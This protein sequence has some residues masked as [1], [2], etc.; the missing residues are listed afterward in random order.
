MKKSQILISTYLDE[1]DCQ[2]DIS[3]EKE[4]QALLRDPGYTSMSELS[5]HCRVSESWALLLAFITKNISLASIDP[6]WLTGNEKNLDHAFLSSRGL[7]IND[8]LSRLRKAE[9]TYSYCIFDNDTTDELL[10][11]RLAHTY[12]NILGYKVEHSSPPTMKLAA[13]LIEN[14]AAVWK[15]RKQGSPQIWS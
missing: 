14:L 11:V 7:P 10:F 2:M 12:L 1:I 13:Y 4:M 6:I 5:E 8:G 9:K 15:T 3:Q